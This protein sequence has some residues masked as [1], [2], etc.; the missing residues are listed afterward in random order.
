MN[1]FEAYTICIIVIVSDGNTSRWLDMAVQ[2]ISE[3]ASEL[4]TIMTHKF[5]IHIIETLIKHLTI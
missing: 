4:K 1:S 2:L 3:E 5:N